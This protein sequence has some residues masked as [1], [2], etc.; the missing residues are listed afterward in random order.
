V[1]PAHAHE[2]LK[3]RVAHAHSSTATPVDDEVRSI[4]ETATSMKDR[5]HVARAIEI[6]RRS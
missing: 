5:G 2:Y 6:N 1:R 3:T 4:L